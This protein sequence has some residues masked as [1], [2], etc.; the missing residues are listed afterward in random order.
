MKSK[1]KK[2]FFKKKGGEISM[3]PPLE[4][5]SEGKKVLTTGIE[6]KINLL[7]IDKENIDR[8]L[9]ETKKNINDL[10]KK[11][12]SLEEKSKKCDDDIS[13]LK[14][15]IKTA[16]EIKL[17]DIEPKKEEEDYKKDN[18]SENNGWGIFGQSGG[19]RKKNIKKNR[20][21]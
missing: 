11:K 16:A 1:G 6:H 19:S 13:K 8:E 12:E 5:A 14:I 2:K 9:E 10:V 3:L 15:D 7:A 4:Q 18:K 21:K 17:L 20:K